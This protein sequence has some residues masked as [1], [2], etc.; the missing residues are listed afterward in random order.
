MIYIEAYQVCDELLL[1][2]IRQEYKGVLLS[3][4][5]TDLLYSYKNGYIFLLSYGVVVFGNVDEIDQTNFLQ[6]LRAFHQ[7]DH[8]VNGFQEDFKISIKP[9][10]DAPVFAYNELI[11]PEL[12]NDVLRITLLQV[13][14]ST[15]LDY[16]QA[17]AQSLLDETTV[18]VNQLEE[19]GSLRISKKKLL[20]TIGKTLNTKNR[21][22]DNLYILDS[23]PIV[24]EKEQ[25]GKI[26]AGLYKTF[27]LGVRFREIDYLLK[28]VESNLSLFIDLTNERESHRLEWVI[29]ILILIEVFHLFLSG[30]F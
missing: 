7:N 4:T 10:L 17:S 19:F 16:Y 23:P 14:Q 27:D 28:M 12:D 25:V 20:K 8:L 30:F 13:A 29:I 18:L 21:I 15:A 26:N 11:V 9:E 1:K 3:E 2:K 6:M 24:W 22:F 5:A